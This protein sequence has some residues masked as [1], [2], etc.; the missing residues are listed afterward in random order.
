MRRSILIILG[1]FLIGAIG[2]GTSPII[3][4]ITQPS[5]GWESYGGLI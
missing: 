3:G 1:C 2:M 5:G 4:I